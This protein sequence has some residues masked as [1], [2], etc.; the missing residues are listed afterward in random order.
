[1][2]WEKRGSQKVYYRSKCLNGHIKKIYLGSGH[3]AKQAAAEDAEKRERRQRE[4]TERQHIATLNEETQ[5]L[6]NHVRTLT[7]AAYIAA[8]FWL[9]NRGEWRKKR[10]QS[11]THEGDNMVPQIQAQEKLSSDDLHSL[12]LRALTGDESTLPTIKNLLDNAPAI[13]HDA[14]NIT[15]KVETAWIQTI[16]GQDLLT[17]ETLVRQVDYLKRTLQAEFS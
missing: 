3:Q 6:Y 16:A 13:W 8:G 9:H 4:C 15:K 1:M 10:Q 11:I 14:F 5:T 7:R 12:I 2:A 17:R